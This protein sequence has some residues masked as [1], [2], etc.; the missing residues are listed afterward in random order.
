MHRLLFVFAFT[1]L[2]SLTLQA[3][4]T[5]K[6]AVGVNFTDWSKNPETGEYK[7]KV[8]YQVGATFTIGKKI[9][10]EP[11]IFYVQKSTE[12]VNQNTNLGD[13]E[14]DLKGIRVPLGIGIDIL[15]HE[16]SAIGLRAMG[17]VSAFFLT[18]AEGHTAIP[19]DDFNDVSWGLYAGA[20]LN[21]TIVFLEAQY[22][23][24][25]TDITKS[26]VDVGQT[27]SIFVNVGVR[28]PF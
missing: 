2:T 12:L 13:V 20:G 9:S 27:R 25:L 26:S 5:I 14:F 15:G 24:S 18:D 23:W 17:G 16:Q 28:I 19:P 7:S 21:F 1:F 3:Q 22:E 6:P 4:L 11:G 10:F 8:G